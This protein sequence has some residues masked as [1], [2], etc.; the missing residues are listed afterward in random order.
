[1]N[2]DLLIFLSILV[3]VLVIGF[4]AGIKVKS[5]KDTREKSSGSPFSPEELAL[6]NKRDTVAKLIDSASGESKQLLS[7]ELANICVEL[8]KLRQE[9]KYSKYSIIKAA[10]F[11]HKKYNK[12]K[13]EEQAAKLEE[14]IDSICQK[15][16]IWEAKYHEA[17]RI[18][19]E[20]GAKIKDYQDKLEK[21]KYHYEPSSH[22]IDIGD[23]TL[24]E[25]S[26]KP[27]KIKEDSS[28]ISI[29]DT[30][31][32]YDNALHDLENIAD[33][34]KDDIREWSSR[35]FADFPEIQQAYEE[36]V[37]TDK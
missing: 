24:I 20:T 28:E 6:I 18:R 30:A 21:G 26:K 4:F 35:M 27:P 14:Y 7:D 31:V 16:D 19:L 13:K 33:R 37:K 15:I 36:A 8:K 1:M 12:E 11:L 29:E 32:R 17:E 9:K 3:L 22:F 23:Y 25:V 34:L 2:E 10:F 5:K